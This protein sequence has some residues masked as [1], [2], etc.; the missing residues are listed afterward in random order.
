MG[1]RSK[2]ERQEGLWIA[3]GSLVETPGHAFYDRLNA[4]IR[5]Y[6]DAGAAV[7]SIVLPPPEGRPAD[8]PFMSVSEGS[9]LSIVRMPVADDIAL[10]ADGVVYVSVL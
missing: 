5:K 10:D 8:G 7:D 9:G 4:V 6:D 2:R 1:K 3:T